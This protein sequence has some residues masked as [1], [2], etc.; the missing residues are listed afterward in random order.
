MWKP[1]LSSLS[2]RPEDIIDLY[3]HPHLLN[4]NNHYTS[5]L[6]CGTTTAGTYTIYRID[7]IPPFITPTLY[8]CVCVCIIEKNKNSKQNIIFLSILTFFF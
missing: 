6:A 1:R 4:V 3:L 2:Y 8:V 7:N 5:I